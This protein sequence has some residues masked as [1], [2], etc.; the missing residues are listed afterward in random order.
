MCTFRTS[1]T[2]DHCSVFLPLMFYGIPNLSFDFTLSP[3]QQ[4]VNIPIV[5]DDIFEDT[6]S[7]FVRLTNIDESGVSLVPRSISILILDNDRK[8]HNY[9]V[10]TLNHCN[11]IVSDN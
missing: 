7:F 5:D 11:Q 10:E 1:D 2:D 8:Q 3:E 6:E 9:P 4:C